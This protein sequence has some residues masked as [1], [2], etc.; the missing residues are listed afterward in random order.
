[1]NNVATYGTPS[2]TPTLAQLQADPGFLSREA[3]QSKQGNSTSVDMVQ[4]G[5]AERVKLHTSLKCR[6]ECASPARPQSLAQLHMAFAILSPMTPQKRMWAC[7]R[8]E[9]CSVEFVVPL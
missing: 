9:M 2:C 8:L 1:M 4:S 5:D 6:P 3:L 7:R